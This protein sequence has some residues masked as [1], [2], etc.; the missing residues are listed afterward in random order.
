MPRAKIYAAGPM[1]RNVDHVASLEA[2]G[3]S[4]AWPAANLAPWVKKKDSQ[5]DGVHPIRTN[6]GLDAGRL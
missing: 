2:S 4:L 1:R 5:G 3:P 6:P